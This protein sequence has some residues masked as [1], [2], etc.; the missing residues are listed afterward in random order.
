[1]NNN[2]PFFSIILPTYN[3]ENMIS[4][5]I[6]SVK[7]QRFENWELIIV[8]DGSTDNTKKEL[9]ENYINDDKRIKYFFQEN[10]ERSAARNNGISKSNGDWICFLDSDDTYYHSHLLEFNK[11]IEKNEFTKGLYFCG[12]SFDV[13]SEKPFNYNI[14]HENNF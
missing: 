11:L 13:Y 5:A 3:R 7:S 4:K 2:N 8:D 6:E 12:L 9:I 1:M 10:S 14:N